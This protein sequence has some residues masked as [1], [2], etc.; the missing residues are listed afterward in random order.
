MLYSG[1][2]PEDQVLLLDDELGMQRDRWRVYQANDL[3]HVAYEALLKFCLDL[4]ASYPAGVALQDLIAEAI[5]EIKSSL[6]DW[7]QTWRQ[8]VSDNQPQDIHAERLLCASIMQGSRTSNFCTPEMAW[9]AL[10]LLAIVYWRSKLDADTIKDEFGR[11]DPMAFRSVFTETTYLHTHQDED[12][13]AV[14][15]ALIEQRIIRRHLWVA[16]R[17]LRY[18]GDYTFLI[19]ADEG[20]VRLRQQYGPV[21]TNPR[22]G[23][24]TTFLTDIYLVDDNGLT[25]RGRKA[26]QES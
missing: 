18:Q 14:I 19:E 7:P 12:F 4:L 2:G 24:A 6:D 22:L 15:G 10:R 20:R 17:K 1:S 3:L 25:E 5:G 8:F 23:P 21:F 13:A 16:L 9:D 11:L 26:L